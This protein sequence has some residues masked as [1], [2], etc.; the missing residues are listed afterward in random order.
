M[1]TPLRIDHVALPMYDVEGTRRFYGQTLG[2][3]LAAAYSGDEWEGRAWLMMIFADAQG[4]QI[5]LCGFRGLRRRREAIPRDARHYALAAATRAQLA[6]WRTKLREARVEFREENHGTQRS[7][8][9]DDPNGNILE[10]TSPPTPRA[11]RNARAGAVVDRW[12]KK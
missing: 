12:L 11:K 3:P 2:L 4:R 6:A 9:F 7:I 1:D 10:I 8:Y 5:A